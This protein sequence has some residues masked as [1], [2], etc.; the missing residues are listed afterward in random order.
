MVLLVR[1]N[2]FVCVGIVARDHSGHILGT[3]SIPFPALFSPRAAEA[4]GFREAL[5]I[6]ANK[7]FSSDNGRYLKMN[8]SFQ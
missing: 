5:V 6:A 4:L 3:V 7:G 1:K 8:D 2:G